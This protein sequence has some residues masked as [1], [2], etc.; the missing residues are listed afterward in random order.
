MLNA[1]LALLNEIEKWKKAKSSAKKKKN[2]G[3]SKSQSINDDDELGFHFIAY[4][5]VKGEV[6]RLDGLQ[7]QPVNLGQPLSFH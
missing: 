7:R 3:T 6:W 2:S 5:P 1:D 4:V